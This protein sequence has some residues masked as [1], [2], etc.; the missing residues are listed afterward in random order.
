M[1]DASPPLRYDLSIIESWITPGS[2][3]LGLGCGDGE[4]LAALKHRKQVV[5][6]GI[7][8][9]EALVA[10]CIQRGLTVV[11]GDIN[12]EVK[13]YPDGF[14]DYVIC[15]QTL[16]Q[17]YDPKAIIGEMLRVGKCAVVS[18]PNFCHWRIRFQMMASGHVPRTRELPFEWYDTPNIRVLSLKD[19]R[20]FA[21]E[22]GFTILKEAAINTQDMGNS[23]TEVRLLP[24]IRATYGIYLIG[25]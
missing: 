5:E 25:R 19:F 2:R 17:A 23:G 16:Q 6:T 4:L 11:Q 14:F 15:S 9:D 13:D 21:K 20:R 12:E 8:I 18:F 24:N 3:V 7:E 10:R 1:S 22:V